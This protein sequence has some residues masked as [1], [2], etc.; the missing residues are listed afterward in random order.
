[1]PDD[2]IQVVSLSEIDGGSV[3]AR[4]AEDM[5]LVIRNIRDV[6]TDAAAGAS[7]PRST[8]T[9]NRR[10]RCTKRTLPEPRGK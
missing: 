1:M 6:N 10:C 4:F 5:D 3:L 7:S 2:R 9:T 8:T